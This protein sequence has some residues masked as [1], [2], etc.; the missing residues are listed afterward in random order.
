MITTT[1]KVVVDIETSGGQK[2]TATVDHKF[3]TSKGW[4]CA[5]EFDPETELAVLCDS[6]R[7]Q[8]SLVKSISRSTQNLVADITTVSENHSFIGGRGQFLV[9]NS[10]MGKQAIAG[11]ALN[12]RDLADTKTH[13]L[14][15]PQKPPVSTW[16]SSL[17]GY[18]E[19]PAGQA[20]VVGIMCYT[21][22]N[23][24]D[25]VILNQAALDRGLFRSTFYRS[26]KESEVT[27]GADEERF[28]ADQEGVLG[29]R[30][31]DYSK[32]SESG[33]LPIAAKVEKDTVLIGKTIEYTVV[34]KCHNG[35]EFISKRAKRDRSVVSKTEEISSVR[36]V[37]I[38]ATKDGL[39]YASVKT[40]ASR[41]PEI[42]DKFC[43]ATDHEVLTVNGWLPIADISKGDVVAVL[44]PITHAVTYEPTV[45]T[46]HYKVTDELMYEID[47]LAVSLK[48]TLNHRLLVCRGDFLELQ[49]ARDLIHQS[50]IMMIKRAS[51]GHAGTGLLLEDVCTPCIENGRLAAWCL[52]L[53]KAE[54]QDVLHGLMRHGEDLSTQGK[55]DLQR[56]AL[57]A[58]CSADIHHGQINVHTS[59]SSNHPIVSRWRVTRW[60]GMV[61]CLTVR[62]GIIYIRRHGKPVWCG[63]SSRHGQKGIV[64]MILPEVDMP[65][66]KEGIIPDI[67]INPHAIPSRMTIGQLIES[68]LGKVACIEGKITDGTPFRNTKPEDINAW[69]NDEYGKE[70]MFNGK[71]GVP[72]KY[73]A[74]LG[75]T[76]YQRL[77]HMVQD[78][79]HA[80]AK[81]PNQILTRQPV[82]G[83]SRK[84]GFRMGEME[85]DALIGHGGSAVIK[86]RLMEQSDKYDG[87]ICQTCGFMAEPSAPSNTPC[88]NILHKNP[89]CRYCKSNDNISKVRIPYAFKLLN[90]ELGAVHLGMKFKLDV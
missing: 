58:G 29:K 16:I 23:Q 75:V 51:R 7:V 8:F 42:G 21:G 49:E 64:G 15:Y 35:E 55:D 86:D 85:R 60:T 66:N 69:T 27:H 57:H 73:K 76:Y 45:D 28:T 89:Y 43:Y 90:Q 67:I 22:F 74:F 56:L 59:R 52:Q 84:G 34:N 6:E 12:F 30:K 20:C 81:G 24:E 14:D 36:S 25:S 77:R 4:K 61:H 11:Q 63:N 82:E 78:K 53:G 48:V 10:A 37:M 68:L 18:D 33:I 80:R 13:V 47:S 46:Q 88:V 54:S 70:T 9:H 2:V 83:R 72:M 31:A 65:F 1:E 41:V 39:K 44:D 26:I 17:V 5:L 3:M 87:F 79:L 19:Q 62:T 38:N 50:S 40:A 71:T 32:L